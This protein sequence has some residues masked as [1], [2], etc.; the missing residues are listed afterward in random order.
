M[1]WRF[2]GH[3]AVFGTPD[4]DG[5]VFAP[6]C[7]NAFL[8]NPKHLAIPMLNAHD[9]EHHVGRW[10][11]MHQDGFGLFVVGELFDDLGALAS[12]YAGLSVKTINAQRSAIPNVWGGKLC[13]TTGIEEISLVI[14][15]EHP[16]ARIFGS[17]VNP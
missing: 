13:L 2:Y 1:G 14:P 4:V 5:N 15:P 17:W 12:P 9:P 8:Q 3:A 16:A 10:L 11:R 7:F 6:S